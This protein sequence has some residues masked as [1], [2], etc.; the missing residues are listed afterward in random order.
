MAAASVVFPTPPFPDTAIT[1]AVVSIASFLSRSLM[2]LCAF[3]DTFIDFNHIIIVSLSTKII[4][5]FLLFFVD[6]LRWLC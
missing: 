5:D 6:Y 2:N 3:L 4:K 1:F